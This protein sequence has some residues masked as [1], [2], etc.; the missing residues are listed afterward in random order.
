MGPDS[1]LGRRVNC[2]CV[3]RVIIGTMSVVSQGVHICTAGHDYTVREF[4]I[5]SL[6]ITIG[7]KAWICSEAFLSPGVRIGN[8]TV[9]GARSVVTKDQPDMCVCAGNPCKAIKPREFEY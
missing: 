6:P 9:I 3:D 8:G 7:D 2:Y 5:V 1:C 4:P